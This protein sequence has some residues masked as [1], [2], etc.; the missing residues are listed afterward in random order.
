MR[1]AQLF[2]VLTLL[3]VLAACSQPQVVVRAEADAN[4]DGTTQALSDIEVRLYPF[5]RDAVFDSL[6]SA[7]PSPEPEIPPD[8][9]AAQD[10]VAEA[11]RNWQV[12]ETEWQTMR[13]RLQTI[14]EEIQGLN[15]GE[16]RYVQLF[17]EFR[18][19]ES[20]VDA[21]ERASRR[22]F[23]EFTEIQQGFIQRADE[24]RLLREQWGDEAF[25]TVSEVFAA[26]E[27]AAGRTIMYDTTGAAGMTDPLALPAG[28]WW[29]VAFYELPFDELYWNVPVTVEGGAE[30]MTITLTNENAVRRPKL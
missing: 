15:R 10:S 4:D 11:Q 17:N 5:D 25:A 21:A 2:S 23:E 3:G 12:A 24:V 6:A 29:V 8:L 19:L 27:A 7:A 28:E 1:S 30:P 22:A 16:S 13:D 18:D 14:N 20:R 9:L 26:R